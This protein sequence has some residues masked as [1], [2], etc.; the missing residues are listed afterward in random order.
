LG[1][2]LS[3]TTSAAVINDDTITAGMLT[4]ALKNFT[5]DEFT[6]AAAQ[7]TFTLTASVGSVNALLA[8]IDGIVQPTTAYSLPTST[9][10]QFITA[11][12]ANSIIRC[13][14]LGFQSTVGVPSD[15][16]VTTAKIAA[17][18][19][20]SAK[21]LAGTIVTADIADDAI[22]EAKIAA[23]TI[24]EASILPNTVTNIS[25]A[26][27][28]VTGT[29]IAS[30]S[31]D[32]T[33]IALGSDTQ[34]DVMFYD[35]TNWARLGPGTAGY[36]LRTGGASANPTW[37]GAGS[38]GSGSIIQ[39]R[40]VFTSALSNTTARFGIPNT[41]GMRQIAAF[42]NTEGTE[43]LTLAIT[44]TSTS[45][46]LKFSVTINFDTSVDNIMG[47]L[48]LY[49]DAIVNAL[50]VGI[51]GAGSSAVSHAGDPGIMRLDHIMQV[52]STSAQTYKIRVGQSA[53]VTTGTVYINQSV[54]A[55][56]TNA[57]GAVWGGV[58]Q[59]SM[60]IVE[61]VP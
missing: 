38:T 42:P 41:H 43:L 18:A 61:Y 30:N 45:N 25:I 20:T 7:T 59:S 8:Y 17:N 44:P 55:G 24:T 3:G 53:H 31:I 23:Q 33:K 32:G 4:T 52:P 54:N 6:G 22:T 10:I 29:Q 1:G 39:S 9:S 13:L 58:N 28:T 27:A 48:C 34:G 26:N 49:R 37:S 14:H 21:I 5:V 51:A 36:H 50:Q 2:H 19:V 60:T 12:P 47:M 46:Y 15:G 56:Q 16:T 57:P 35:G 40:S 11:P